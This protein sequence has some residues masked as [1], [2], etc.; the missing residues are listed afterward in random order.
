MRGKK[1]N[2]LKDIYIMSH[3]NRWS[4]IFTIRKESVAEHSFHVA[5][6][7][8]NLRDDY[9]F[10]LGTALAMAIC[11][12]MP[13]IE[14]NDVP[15]VIKK[16]YPTIDQAF[17][18]CEEE[19][20]EMLPYWCRA[21]CKAYARNDSIEASIVHLADAMQCMQY[22]EVEINLGNHNYF[23]QVFVISNERIQELKN[24]LKGD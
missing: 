18:V 2:F 17:Q 21:S 14:L 1:I 3:I 15:R 10:N 4:T 20:I 11:H 24:Y 12:D 22:A 7:V 6:I 16:K 5:A 13:E 9:D 8:M 23:D 19:V